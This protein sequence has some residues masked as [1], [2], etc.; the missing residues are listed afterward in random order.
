MGWFV[1]VLEQDVATDARI[2]TNSSE[3]L[4]KCELAISSLGNS[5]EN[6]ETLECRFFRPSN[7]VLIAN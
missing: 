6:L 7:S 1:D 4:A 2:E 3:I 5:L